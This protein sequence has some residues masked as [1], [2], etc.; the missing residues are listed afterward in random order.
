MAAILDFS[1]ETFYDE[2]NAGMG[3]LRS[4]LVYL[5]VLHVILLQ[6]LFK[7]SRFTFSVESV[8]AILDSDLVYHFSDVYLGSN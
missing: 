3:L 6:I 8:A 5:Y 1:M 4:N 7:L 2:Y